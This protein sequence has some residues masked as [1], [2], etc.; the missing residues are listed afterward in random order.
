M[1]HLGPHPRPPE[2]GTLGMRPSNLYFTKLSSD[3]DEGSKIGDL[4]L[5]TKTSMKAGL[6]SFSFRIGTPASKLLVQHQLTVCS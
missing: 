6:W 5:Q 1:K 4:W 3:T 2:L